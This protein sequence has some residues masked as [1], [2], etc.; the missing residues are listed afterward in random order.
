LA[1]GRLEFQRGLILRDDG[2][3]ENGYERSENVVYRDG[4]PLKVCCTPIQ[5]QSFGLWVYA[6]LTEPL[7]VMRGRQVSSAQKNG[8]H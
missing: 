7:L 2:G 4:D 8:A 5:N 3:D 6:R 1:Q